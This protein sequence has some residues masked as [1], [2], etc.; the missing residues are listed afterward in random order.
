MDNLKALSLI[1][2]KINSNIMQLAFQAGEEE[3]H[4][5]LLSKYIFDQSHNLDLW[6]KNLLLKAIFLLKIQT[7]SF[8]PNRHSSLPFIIHICSN[9]NLINLI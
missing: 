3:L 2:F 1:K 8:D 9:T 6:R 5:K 4:N 7:R